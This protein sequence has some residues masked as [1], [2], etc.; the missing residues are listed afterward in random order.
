[1]DVAERQ[2]RPVIQ[3]KHIGVGK[4]GEFFAAYV[5][6]DAGADVHILNGEYDLLVTVNGELRKVEVKASW[7]RRNGS[8]YTFYKGKSS[9]EYFVLVAMD[10]RLIRILSRNDM[11]DGTTRH[12]NSSEF[13]ELNQLSDIAEFMASKEHRDASTT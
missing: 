12:V 9:A 13:S 8:R 6:Q 7:S 5:L 11:G 10:T 4:A 2:S 1:M 3:R